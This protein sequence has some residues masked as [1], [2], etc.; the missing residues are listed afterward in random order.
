MDR[1]TRCP[2]C[3]TRME[4]A[5]SPTGRTELI[6]VH[7]DDADLLRIAEALPKAGDVTRKQSTHR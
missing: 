5:P 1:V 2:H 4:P 7:C 3:G 6:C